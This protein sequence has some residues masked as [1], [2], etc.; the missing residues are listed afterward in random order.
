M[1][2]GVHDVLLHTRTTA[3]QLSYRKRCLLLLG[4][5]KWKSQINPGTTGQKYF[6]QI[7]WQSSKIPCKQE[8]Q[9]LTKKTPFNFASEC[10]DGTLI[11]QAILP[12]AAESS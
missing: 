2:S 8:S 10:Q 9:G 3:P 7:S 6:S 12:V 11:R 4:N 5:S 1:Q